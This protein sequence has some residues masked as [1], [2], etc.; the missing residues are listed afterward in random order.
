VIG[1]RRAD[2]LIVE[3]LSLSADEALAWGFLDELVSGDELFATALGWCENLLALPRENMLANRA[4]AR[5]DMGE[6][7]ER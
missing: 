2:R 4:M 5:A 7:L 1:S 3:G 6:M